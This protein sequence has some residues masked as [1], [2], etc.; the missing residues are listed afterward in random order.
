MVSACLYQ[1]MCP[2]LLLQTEHEILS[3]VLPHFARSQTSAKGV[4][5]E[6]QD[7]FYKWYPVSE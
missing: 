4:T 7:F 1:A 6:R 5:L 3:I 2:G